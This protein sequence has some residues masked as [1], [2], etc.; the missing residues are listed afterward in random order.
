MKIGFGSLALPVNLFLKMIDENKM[1]PCIGKKEEEVVETDLG[2]VV[3]NEI[4][5]ANSIS[6][7]V[8][9]NGLSK[10]NTSTSLS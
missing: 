8:S 7:T 6:Q 10:K 1:C 2:D 9:Q 5:K 4:K 3:A